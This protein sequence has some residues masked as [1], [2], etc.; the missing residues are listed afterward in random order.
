MTTVRDEE[1]FTNIKNAVNKLQED[2]VV[3]STNLNEL[4]LQYQA[5]EVM[6][7]ALGNQVES[8][9]DAVKS[10]SIAVEKLNAQITNRVS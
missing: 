1:A 6:A 3:L 8:I 5:L 9:S 2:F 10:L 4:K 7:S